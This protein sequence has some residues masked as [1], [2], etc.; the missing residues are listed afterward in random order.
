LEKY[1]LIRVVAH[2]IILSFASFN[3]LAICN[4]NLSSSS[5]SET[6]GNLLVETQSPL[7]ISRPTGTNASQ[8]GYAYFFF[9]KGSAGNYN[10]KAYNSL[11]EPIDYNLFQ[12]PGGFSIL[13]NE[14]DFSNSNEYV[15]IYLQHPT[16]TFN[17]QF[18][19]R[20]PSLSNVSLVRGGTY[21]DSISMSVYRSGINSNFAYYEFSRIIPVTIFVPKII[22]ISLVEPG[23]P[24]DLNST[25]KTLNFGDLETNEELS[26]DLMIASNAGYRV[27][28]SSLNNGKLKNTVNINTINYSLYVSGAPINLNG[29]SSTPIPVA[30]GAGVSGA[31]GV[32]LPMRVKIGTVNDANWGDYTDYITVTAQTND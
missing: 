9:S 12:G 28:V 5:I 22:N 24:I 30:T 23:S 18:Y 20:L 11:G 10:R 31:N 1:Q 25:F 14:Y 29:S 13:K 21:T 2:T 15:R 32:R 16:T 17:S 3:L 6:A 26:F 19:F 8:C 27:S 4:F 7:S